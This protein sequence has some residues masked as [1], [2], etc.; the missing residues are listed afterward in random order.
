MIAASLAS[1]AITSWSVQWCWRSP[2]ACGL[3]EHPRVSMVIDGDST[4]QFTDL[5][6]YLD[7]TIKDLEAEHRQ[8]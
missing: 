8:A 5:R 6:P 3:R 4:A 1:L 2:G 7:G